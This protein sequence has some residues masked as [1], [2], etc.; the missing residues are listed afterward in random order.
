M[1]YEKLAET[2]FDNSFEWRFEFPEVLDEDGNFEGFDIVMENPPYLSN[3]DINPIDKKAYFS[4]YNGLSDDLYNYFFTKSFELLKKDGLFTMIVSNTFM[5]I[6]SKINIRRLLQSK[7]L[8]EFMPIK[9]P[10]EEATIEP[11]IILAQNTN[12]KKNYIFDYIDLRKKEFLPQ[13]NR[14]QVNIDIYKNAP[15]EVFFTPSMQNLEIYRKIIKK[16]KILKDKWWNKIKSSRDIAKN[17]KELQLYRDSLKEGDITLLGLVTEGGQGLATANNGKYIGVKEGREEADRVKQTRIE[18]LE[19]FN[20]KY[21]QKYSIDGVTELEI[22]ELFDRLKEDFGRD[23]FGQG[24]LF[25][26]VTNDAIAD[27]DTLTDNEKVNGISGYRSFVPYD[28]G[29]KG[30]NQ[31]YLKTPFYIDWSVENVKFLK[32][33]TRARYQG[34]NFFFKEGFSW[35]DV[36]NP[37]SEYIKARQKQKTINDVKTMALYPL[38]DKVTSKYITVLLNSYILFKYQR[39]IIN[40]TVSIQIND[41]RQIPII[42][43][44]QEQLNKF[45]NIFDE[46]K[47]IKIKEFNNSLPENE[48]AQKL[49]DIQKRVDKMVY[50]LY[51]I[52]PEER[53]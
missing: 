38:C 6:N 14:Y 2:L 12:T 11:V 46:A 39:E 20:K 22:R 9:N 30:G 17:E 44:N 28:K 33:D 21:N 10:F 23:V 52:S 8:I 24:Y 3:K 34:Y 45:E 49:N 1:E 35:S 37:N 25:R 5:T 36:L 7:K 32:S 19:K 42:V 26:I 43:P 41:I 18:K 51:G 15:N 29:D 16:V 40:N 4:L 48:V 53:N 13:T 47:D 50:E 31:W 27:V